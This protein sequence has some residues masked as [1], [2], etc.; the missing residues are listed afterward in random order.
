[1]SVAGLDAVHSLRELVVPRS[2]RAM[3]QVVRAATLLIGVVAVGYFAVSAV[4]PLAPSV[5]VLPLA[6]ILAWAF[7]AIGGFL[8]GE[9]R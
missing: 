1:M 7:I 9:A 5:I 8:L 2:A 4:V 3:A 6:A